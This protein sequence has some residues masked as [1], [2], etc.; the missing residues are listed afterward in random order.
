MKKKFVTEDEALGRGVSLD[1]L[2]KE[3][4]EQGYVLRNEFTHEAVG[5][6]KVMYHKDWLKSIEAKLSNQHKGYLI[7]DVMVDGADNIHYIVVDKD[8]SW[9]RLS[10][11][12]DI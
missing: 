8:D 11:S 7:R 2:V 1:S 4:E 10:C 3:Q 9:R 6:V 5:K 12:G